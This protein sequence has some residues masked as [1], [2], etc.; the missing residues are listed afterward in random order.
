MLMSL[1]G[2]RLSRPKV[3]AVKTRAHLHV[4][5]MSVSLGGHGQPIHLCR[6]EFSKQCG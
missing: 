6:E 1:P 4:N 2:E 3:S 5:Y